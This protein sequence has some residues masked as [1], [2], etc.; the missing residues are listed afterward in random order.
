MTTSGQHSG[1]E[2]ER[3]SPIDEQFAALSNVHRRRLFIALLAHD[4][5]REPVIVPDDVHEGDIPLESLQVELFHTHLFRLEEAGFI[6]WNPATHEVTRGPKFDE[7]RPL[8][9]VLRDHA[10]ALPGEWV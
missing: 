3:G 5:Q 2:M 10:E 7:I 1:I 4:Q 9:E 8:L 6:R